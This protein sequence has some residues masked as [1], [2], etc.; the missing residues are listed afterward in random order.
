MHKKL[1]QISAI[2]AIIILVGLYIATFIFAIIDSPYSG[3]M[4]QACLFA[5]IAVPILLWV[6][7]WLYGA[8]TGKNNMAAIFPKNNKQASLKQTSLLSTRKFLQIK[9]EESENADDKQ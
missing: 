4:F 2:I 5:T 8:I 9:K 7:I 6:W 1:R 3:R